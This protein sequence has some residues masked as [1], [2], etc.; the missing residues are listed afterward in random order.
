[1]L[2]R[3]VAG[4]VGHGPVLLREVRMGSMQ[5]LQRLTRDR[6]GSRRARAALSPTVYRFTQV[7]RLRA[8]LRPGFLAS[9][10][11]MSRWRSARNELVA[12]GKKA[13]SALA[14]ASRTASAWPA[15]PP[16]STRAST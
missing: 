4:F 15:L 13:H 2:A 9:T 11:R 8:F 6:A 5:S 12:S 3:D 14:S 16:P 7:N 1:F 10:R